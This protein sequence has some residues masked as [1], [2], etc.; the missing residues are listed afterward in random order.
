[1]E[2]KNILEMDFEVEQIEVQEI[3]PDASSSTSF[4]AD[5]QALW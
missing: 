5:C 3:T 1:M 4:A 2:E